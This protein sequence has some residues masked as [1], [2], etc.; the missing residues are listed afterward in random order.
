MSILGFIG[1]LTCLYF[2]VKL[3]RLLY[4]RLFAKIDLAKYRSKPDSWVVITGGSSG[5]G[6]GYAK[7]NLAY[8]AIS[9]G[10]I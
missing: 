6:L 5:I 3:A 1:L 7:T 8:L 4:V 9:E 2:G 10:R